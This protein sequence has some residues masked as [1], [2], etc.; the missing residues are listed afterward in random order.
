MQTSVSLR[1]RKRTDTFQA[2]HDAAAELVLDR[3]LSSVTV[4]EIAERAGVS[5]RTFFNYFPA[6]EDAVLGVRAPQL[7]ND[8]LEAFR[9]AGDGD[10]FARTV[11]LFANSVRSSIVP[12][13]DPTRRR[14]LVA[15]HPVLRQRYLM[16]VADT[17]RL[18]LQA[19]EEQPELLPDTPEAARALTYLAGAVVRF[20]YTTNPGAISGN[21]D[22]ALDRAID[23]FRKVLRNAL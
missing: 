21:D 9:D 4:D 13:A 11:Q 17:E 18:A 3:G 6:K 16:R 15:D 14:R 2:L 5:Q 20:T 23:T 1:E 8:A 22:E 7:S 10:L 12:S 19:I